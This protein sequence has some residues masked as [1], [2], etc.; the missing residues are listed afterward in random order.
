[1][2]SAIRSMFLISA[3]LRKEGYVATSA[4][5]AV[6]IDITRLSVYVFNGS[7]DIEYYWYIIP[8][9]IIAFAGTTLGIKLLDKFSGM[10]VRRL[11][12]IFLILVGINMLLR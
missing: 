3:R 10:M 2:G 9:I 12:L 11:V 8:L 1:M 4:A 6:I 5:I 7:L